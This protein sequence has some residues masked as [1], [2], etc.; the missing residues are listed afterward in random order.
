MPA[1]LGVVAVILLLIVGI[2]TGDMGGPLF[3]P[4]VFIFMVREENHVLRTLLIHEYR[5]I[6]LRDPML[7]DSMLPT[8]WHGHQAYQLCRDL[9]RALEEP[10]R[11]YLD[12][13]FETRAGRWPRANPD[14]FGRFGGL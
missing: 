12:D 9:Y 4:G 2:I 10:A 6:V 7:P 8:P 3:L 5:K 14:F 13:R 11:H 1:V